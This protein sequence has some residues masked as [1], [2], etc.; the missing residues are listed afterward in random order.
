MGFDEY[1]SS[2][3]TLKESNGH[4]SEELN[5]QHSGDIKHRCR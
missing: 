3:L 4:R 5:F 1:D 2:L